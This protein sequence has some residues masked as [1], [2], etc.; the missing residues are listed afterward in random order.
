M[1]ISSTIM[2]NKFLSTFFSGVILI[3]IWQLIAMVIGNKLLL[4]GPVDTFA[5]LLE[6]FVSGQVLSPLL[7]TTAKALIGLFLSLAVALVLGFF[8][9]LN[10]FI[11]SLFEPA[12]IIIQSVPIISWLALALLWWGI[13]FSSPVYIVFLTLFPILTINVTEGVKNVDG[14]L[15]EMAKAF[16]IPWKTVLSDIYFASAFPFILSA[17]KV[18]VSF[19]WKSVAIAEFMVGTSGIGRKI[20]D[21]KYSLETTDVFAFTIL[22]VI[23]GIISEK[24][25]DFATKEA[26]K[27]AVKA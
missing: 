1:K 15:V 18:G 14:K 12:I 10:R 13:G 25:L 16:S 17:M 27:Y 8:M 7:E 9:G 11:Y 23:L 19:M 21:S 3:G 22:L 26:G 6:L 5:R 2:K 20:S 24:I 4:P